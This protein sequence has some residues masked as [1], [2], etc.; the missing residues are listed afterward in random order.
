MYKKSTN[1]NFIIFDKCIQ[2]LS[3]MII[4]I[5]NC[6]IPSQYSFVLLCNHFPLPSAPHNF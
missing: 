1:F 2:C 4:K 6:V 5:E 3:M